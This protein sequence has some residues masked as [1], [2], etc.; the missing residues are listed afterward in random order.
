[1]LL[2][3]ITLVLENKMGEFWNHFCENY[4]RDRFLKEENIGT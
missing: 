2:I 4:T 3:Y 1:M